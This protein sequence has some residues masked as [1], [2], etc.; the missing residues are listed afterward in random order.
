MNPV[1]TILLENIDKPASLFV[2]P[3]D[4]AAASWADHLCACQR[5][6]IEGVTAGSVKG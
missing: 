6:I 1:E 2:F 5:Y 4:V 3:T